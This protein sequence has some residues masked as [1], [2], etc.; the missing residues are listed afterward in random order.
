MNLEAGKESDTSSSNVGSETAVCA[1]VGDSGGA[2]P[3]LFT[4]AP[5]RL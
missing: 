2:V 3:T 1:A 4:A 5:E